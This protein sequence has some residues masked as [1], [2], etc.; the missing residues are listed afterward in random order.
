MKCRRFGATSHMLKIRT[1]RGKCSLLYVGF[2]LGIKGK[3]S[4]LFALRLRNKHPVKRI[5][6]TV[7]HGL[8]HGM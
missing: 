5:T 8:S 6:V 3:Q 7:P 4:H 2:H 1:R